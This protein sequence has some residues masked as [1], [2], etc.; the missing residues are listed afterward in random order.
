MPVYTVHE[1]PLRA[2]GALAEL[3]RFAFVRDGF[4]WWAFLL[5]PIW[6]LR[7]RLW[8]VLL[9]YV[10]GSAVLES[11]LRVIGAPASVIALT[12]VLISLLIGLEASTLLRFT[13]RRGGWS[14]VGVVSGADVEDAERRFFAAWVRQAPAARAAPPQGPAAPMQPAPTPIPSAPMPY[15]ATSP[16]GDTSGVIGLFPEPGAQR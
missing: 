11:A 15:A 12:A 5:T 14:N 6:M 7:H 16:A 10:V 8:L 13:L 1:P 4:Y 9:I 2:A 3:E